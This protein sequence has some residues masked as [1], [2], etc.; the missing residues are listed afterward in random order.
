MIWSRTTATTREVGAT[1][2][3]W[4][5]MANASCGPTIWR[6][7]KRWW[8]AGY[9][10]AVLS[11]TRLRPAISSDRAEQRHDRRAVPP[12][13][14]QQLRHDPCPHRRRFHARLVVAL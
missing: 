12:R 9:D 13:L 14:P 11:T 8:R 5:S 6:R 4:I 2:L 3:A 10:G 1:S 7:R